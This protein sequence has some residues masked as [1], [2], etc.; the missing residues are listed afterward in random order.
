VLSSVGYIFLRYASADFFHEN[1]VQIYRISDVFDYL[2]GMKEMPSPLDAIVYS[3]RFIW[4]DVRLFV[5]TLVFATP[6]CYYL[7]SKFSFF[8]N[9]IA[10]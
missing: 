4:V 10:D 3:K 7:L 1:L 8:S 9:S 5:F 6:A 2:R